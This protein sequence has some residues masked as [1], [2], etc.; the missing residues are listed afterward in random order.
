M[1]V[2]VMCMCGPFGHETLPKRLYK[3]DIHIYKTTTKR[4]LDCVWFLVK[5][6]L[7]MLGLGFMKNKKCFDF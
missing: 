4:I 6:I 2:M 5:R 7:D 3:K 1:G